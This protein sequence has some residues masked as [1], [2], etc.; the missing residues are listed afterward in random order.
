[1]KK[2]IAL[3]LAI[4]MIAS[5]AL[6]SCNNKKGT[7]GNNGDGGADTEDNGG[8]VIPD[9]FGSSNTTG[10]NADST[11]ASDNQ[12][13]NNNNNQT[14]SASFVD[15]ATQFSVY[16]YV[17]TQ[18]RSSANMKAS[19]VITVDAA[20][21]LTVI[22]KNET[23]YKVKSGADEGYVPQDFV[24]SNKADTEFD[25]FA[26]AEEYK[27]IQI[28]GDADN[29]NKVNIRQYPIVSDY[30]TNAAVKTLSYAETSNGELLMIG[31]NASGNWYKVSY[32]NG[33]Y[34]LKINSSTKPL[35]IVDGEPL[36]S[37][38]SGI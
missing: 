14:P 33:V 24:T 6:V 3:F 20:T 35:L 17:S 5:I 19:E 1:M 2:L 37:T 10:T 21:Q 7:T 34:Y 32:D 31:K 22:A 18:L 11:E 23:W 30:L 9:N 36:G 29:V 13:G 8:L 26:T 25:D 27:T 15:V 4:L 28:K 16:T 12:E 38:S